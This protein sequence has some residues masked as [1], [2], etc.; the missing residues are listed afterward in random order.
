M[1]T[2]SLKTVKPGNRI[3]AEQHNAILQLLKRRVTGP[4]MFEDATGWRFR[5]LN[6]RP[7]GLRWGRVKVT[8]ELRPDP[9]DYILIDWTNEDGTVIYAEDIKCYLLDAS[10]YDNDGHRI[11]WCDLY[12]GTIVQWF[13]YRSK[14]GILYGRIANPTYGVSRYNPRILGYEDTPDGIAWIRSDQ[15]FDEEYGLDGLLCR[16]KIGFAFESPTLIVFD[17][18][19]QFDH[20]GKLMYVG[21]ESKR[22][23]FQMFPVDDPGID[24]GTY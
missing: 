7:D 21:E 6:Q 1:N 12:E 19:I 4:E 9:Y 22:G 5:H 16:F 17:R 23:E 24:G 11:T 3:S 14:D 2:D 10:V 18:L 8:W 20:E 15:H 13:P